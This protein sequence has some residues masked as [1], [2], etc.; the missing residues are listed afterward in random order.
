MSPAKSPTRPSQKSLL[1]IADDD[2]LCLQV[3]Y[4]A[5]SES[6]FDIIAASDGA[7][8]LELARSDTPDVILLDVIMPG[9]GGFEV[10]RR[11]KADPATCEASVIFMTSRDEPQS[12]LEAF[13]VGAVDYISKPFEIAELLA[14]VKTHAS[15]RQ[16]TKALRAE[17][18]ERAAA[19]ASREKLMAELVAQGE[20]LR[21]AYQRIEI[22]LAERER[23]EATRAAL[24]A[25]I[26]D[27]QRERLSELSVPLIPIT[28]EILIMPLVGT[29]DVDR[30]RQLMD[31]ALHGIS[32]R[33]A[34]VVILDVT[35]VRALDAS[36]AAMLVETS[37]ALELLGARAIVTGIS[38]SVAR[39][40]VDIGAP[41]GA[42]ASRGTLQ[43]G[44][45]YAMQV[46]RGKGRRYAASEAPRRG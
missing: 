44:F 8:A 16:L 35:G 41:L 2:T 20:E 22:E 36:V 31:V 12:R 9:M 6:D 11:L 29:I 23:A 28:D 10:C 14:R 45:E 17:N 37:R 1:L 33:R 18:S 27:A 43:T 34:A 4:Q 30:A 39:M 5:L 24:Q 21:R 13:D 26:I 7:M 42:L 3:L 38:P 40:L 25:Q 19:E 32:S 46:S 15:I